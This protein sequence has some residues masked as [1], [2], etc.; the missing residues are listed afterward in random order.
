MKL[1]SI[2]ELKPEKGISY[3][4]PHLYRLIKAKK[5]PKPI[6]LGENRIGFVESE[7]DAW[8]AAKITERDTGADPAPRPRGR[9]RAREAA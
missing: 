8:I 2:D 1:L 9:V 5:F 3:S 6:S 4:R 7:I